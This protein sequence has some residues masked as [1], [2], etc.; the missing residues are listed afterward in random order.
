MQVLIKK[1]YITEKTMR[2]AEGGLYTFIVDRVATKEMIT[3]I[4]RDQFGVEV[5]K[6]KIATFKPKKK[7]Q[8][9]RRGYFMIPGFKKAFVQVKKGQK[10]ALFESAVVQPEDQV[11][12]TTA[13]GEPVT[14]VKEKKSLLRGTKIKIEKAK[15]K[16][17][18]QKSQ[19]KQEEK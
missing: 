8:R 15:G 5:L 11:R 3:R 12:V 1:P 13:E 6:V 17:T 18:A 4:V 9:T 7:L 14:T 10:I 2:L 16:S 19:A